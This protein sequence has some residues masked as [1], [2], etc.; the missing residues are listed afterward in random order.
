MKKPALRRA[1]KSTVIFVIAL[2]LFSAGLAGTT[3]AYFDGE[4]DNVGTWSASSR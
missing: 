1:T 4:A 3:F 2:L